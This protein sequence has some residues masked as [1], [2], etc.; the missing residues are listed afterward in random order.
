MATTAA[1][2][3]NTRQGINFQIPPCIGLEARLSPNLRR[4]CGHWYDETPVGLVVYVRND[5]VNLVDPDGKAWKRQVD[6]GHGRYLYDDRWWE[7]DYIQAD[8]LYWEDSGEEA[9]G[10][11]R[12]EIG[13]GG[14]FGF[15]QKADIDRGKLFE[16]MG[17]FFDDPDNYNLHSAVSTG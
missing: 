3:E 11:E 17:A 12:G 6:I 4:G 9:A 7:F 10:G 2:T 1:L 5:P 15:S 13:S 14:T 8:F 16:K